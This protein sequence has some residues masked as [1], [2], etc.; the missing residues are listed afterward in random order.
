MLGC[1]IDRLDTPGVVARVQDMLEAGEACQ[2]SMVNTAKLVAMQ[3]DGELRRVFESSDLVIAEDEAVVL[4]SRLVRPPLPARVTGAGLMSELLAMAARDNR[5]VY[6]LGGRFDALER[7]LFVA[8]DRY[9]GLDV[10]GHHHGYF[11]GPDEEAHMAEHIRAA[12]PDMLFVAMTSPRREYWLARYGAEL[13]VG[14]RM[15]VGEDWTDHLIQRPQ[16]TWRRQLATR[17]QFGT[18]VARALANRSQTLEDRRAEDR[19]AQDRRREAAAAA[20]ERRTLDR[21]GS[22]EDPRGTG[23]E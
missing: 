10:V 5:T 17:A 16:R 19:R 7:A 3:R 20:D 21:R 9:A 4:A 18:L 11:Y 12:A 14:F 13:G 15:G 2:L 6:V 23:A 8:R 22:A 1:P